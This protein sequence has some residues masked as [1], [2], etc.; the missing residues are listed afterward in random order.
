[1]E[2]LFLMTTLS[3]RQQQVAERVAQGKRETEIAAELG[4]AVN[5]VKVHKSIIYRKLGVR[6]A[7]ELTLA[8]Q[9]AA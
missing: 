4:I 6:N 5:T 8:L 9:R 3:P 2:R 7:V 1:M